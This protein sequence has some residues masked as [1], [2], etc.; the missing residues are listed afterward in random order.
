MVPCR[1][2]VESRGSIP[3]AIRIDPPDLPDSDRLIRC[4]ES[5]ATIDPRKKFPGSLRSSSVSPSR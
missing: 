2:S 1:H 5:T 4:R 3:D